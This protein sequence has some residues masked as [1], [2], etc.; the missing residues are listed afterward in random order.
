MDLE[1][2]AGSDMFFINEQNAWLNLICSVDK[3]PIFFKCQLFVFVQKVGWI[4]GCR[5]CF[6]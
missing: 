5:H 2:S 6:V 3:V 4:Y 1:V